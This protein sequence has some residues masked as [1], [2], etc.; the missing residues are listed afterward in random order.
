MSSI[1]GKKNSLQR[2]DVS[3]FVSCYAIFFP[4]KNI[5]GENGPP[6]LF[7]IE[8]CGSGKSNFSKVLFPDVLYSQHKIITC[9]KMRL[10]PAV[11]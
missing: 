8:K 4:K 3:S 7:L 9:I 6:S 5:V 1:S 11:F 2:K 10:F